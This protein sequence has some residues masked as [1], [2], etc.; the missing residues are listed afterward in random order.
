MSI[1]SNSVRQPVLV[2]LLVLLVIVGGVFSYRNMAQEQFPDVSVDVIM[3]S[4][5]MPGASPKEIE[6]L[7]TIPL[8]EE[9]GNIDEID[10]MTSISS[11]GSSSIMIQ[12][13]S[14][15]KNVF[16][17]LTEVQNKIERVR[18]FPTEAEDPIV[19]EMKVPFDTVTVS[20]VGNAP[21]H[22]VKKFAEELEDGLKMIPGV[23][24]VVVAGLREREIWVECDPHRLYSYGLS[25]SDV[26][27]AIRQR[28]LNLPG[29]VIK[30]GRG[31]FNI[32]TEAEY[33]SI[34][35]ILETVLRDE[36]RDGRVYLRDV[37]TVT[38]T[39]EERRS[40]GRLDGESSINLTVKKDKRSNAI[41]VVRMVRELVAEAVPLLPA[42]LSIR[43][44]N[45]SSIEI[46]DRLRALYQN[47]ALGLVLVVLSFTFFIGWRAALI[48]AAGIPV[49]F[50]GAFI[51][52]NAYGYTV[53][54]LS[55]FGLIL[56]LGLVVDD[57]IV[58]CEN[59][60]RHL[61]AGVPLKEAAVKGAEEITWPVIATVLTSIAAFLPL[62]LMEGVLGK[63]M[64]VI[65][66]VV[67]LALIASLFEALYVLPSHVAEWG[68]GKGKRRSHSMRPWVI[69][70][71]RI[72]EKIISRFLRF[73]YGIVGLTI[74][75]AVFCVNLA[76]VH[77]DF[78]LFGGRDLQAFALAIE[79]PSGASLQETT[80]I[81][82]ELEKRSLAVAERAPEIK[83]IRMEVGIISRGPMGGISGGNV[84]QISF[85]LVG[86]HERE[87]M[88]QEVKDEI[89]EAIRDVA[90]ARTMTFEDARM[91]PPVG[92]PIQLQISSALPE[93]IGPTAARIAAAMAEL[94]GF[95][96][97]EDGRPIPGIEWELK[98]D[99]AEAAKFGADV[100]LIGNYVRMITNGTRLGEY[101]PDG[102]DQE[103]DIVVRLPAAFRNIEQLDSIRVRTALGLVPISNFVSREARP[104]IGILRRVDGRRVMT[105]KAEV[106]PGVL[107]ATKVRELRDWLAAAGLDPRVEIT[108]KGED[109]EQA[110]AQK[111]LIK[112]FTVAIFLMAIILVT[113]FNSFY[114]AFLILSAVIMSTVGVMLGLLITDQPFG[115]IMAGIGVIALAG[116]VVNNNIVLIDTFDRLKKT[117][118]DP[119]EAILRTGA[120]RLRPVLLTT[121]T[122]V[123]GLMPMVL[124]LN[125]DI[126]ARE[127]QI[128]A[129]STQWWRQLATAIAFGLTF[130]TVLTLVVTPSALMLRENLAA[131]WRRRRGRPLATAAIRQLDPELPEAA[132]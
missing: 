113:Q 31:E 4:T 50:L 13:E 73:R 100:T 25:L 59:V 92:K 7:I 69:V 46:T 89:R 34:D 76:V 97:I 41:E 130:A 32:R 120:Q 132:E 17:K 11:D 122:T 109:K 12:L 48:I 131:W 55:L 112:A 95:V 62:L 110:A 22:I 37:A 2:N 21:E 80:R 124:G 78:I 30:M 87:R 1:S 119:L 26:S 104:K 105:V 111:F 94:G 63:F 45:D 116:I 38:D 96:D 70:L 36:G 93:L 57:A 39:F 79:A 67:T 91:G 71:T 128:G 9:F 107:P 5:L 18:N 43:I 44:V 74:A 47:F 68:T 28:N 125:V 101:R 84:G 103:I 8:E 106:A 35:Q 102:S 121:I 54:M 77:M 115:I 58:V 6:E 88:G 72:Y 16:E 81:L 24:Q 126:I 82:D 64:G 33:K 66:V 108:F 127:V 42:G 83:H 98:V 75:I 10:S 49:A 40:L 20:L 117:A 86:L 29:G 56:V 99:R 14:G 90:G 15:V 53:N 114:S 61:E 23:E 27:R 51:F 129:P 118:P 3:I 123:L 60:Y 52:L 85:E 65:P 19:Q